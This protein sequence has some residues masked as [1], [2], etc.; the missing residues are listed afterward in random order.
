MHIIKF[1]NTE[2]KEKVSQDSG[3]EKKMSHANISNQ[4]DFIIL[5][6]KCVRQCNEAVFFKF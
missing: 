6:G 2:S 4:N 1:Q 3:K 5:K